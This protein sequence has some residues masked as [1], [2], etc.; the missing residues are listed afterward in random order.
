MVDLR[1]PDC[2]LDPEL[3]LLGIE[4]ALGQKIFTPAT[5]LDPELVLREIDKAIG[6]GRSIFTPASRLDPLLALRQFL[7][8]IGG[9]GPAPQPPTNA[10]IYI[11]LV[12]RRAWVDGDEVAVD[13][14]L[15]SDANTEN[16]WG[17]SSYDPAKLTADG[18]VYVT[19]GS[20]F[21]AFIGPALS[22]VLDAAT[23]VVATKRVADNSNTTFYPLIAMSADGNDAVEV[24]LNSAGWLYVLS[25]GGASSIVALSGRTN[26]GLGS[27]NRIAMTLTSDRLDAA[28]NAYAAGAG[29]LTATDRP[30]GNPLVAAGV[31]PKAN[32]AIQ[33]IAIYDALPN[34]TGL[35]ELSDTGLPNTPPAIAVPTT[36]QV[37]WAL[38][39]SDEV[40]QSLT[41]TGGSPIPCSNFTTFDQYSVQVVTVVY[42]LIDS[43][44]GNFVISTLDP[45]RVDLVGSAPLT[46]GDHTFV[47]RATDDVGAYTEQNFTLMVVP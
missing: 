32:N 25:Y 37:E 22:M 6:G 18:Y 23:I 17:P 24:D 33:S 15:G 31:D 30:P 39:G 28:A 42:T 5:R 46:I 47:L 3:M 11:D 26:V 44:G 45:H 1:N 38:S 7:A 29:P 16:A 12:A 14:L 41:Y 35:S 4:E 10:R 19:D 2:V 43:D 34:T 27:S 20:D 13:T 36:I 8:A 21:P 40:S 9:G